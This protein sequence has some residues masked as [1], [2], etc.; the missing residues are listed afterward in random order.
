MTPNTRAG[1]AFGG[2]DMAIARTGRSEPVKMR[3]GAITVAPRPQ[4]SPFSRSPGVHP[5]IER[6]YDNPGVRFGDRVKGRARPLSAA[7]E[8]SCHFSQT[9]VS[10]TSPIREMIKAARGGRKLTGSRAAAQV[11]YMERDGA[12]EQIKLKEREKLQG[13][14]FVTEMERC[15]KERSPAAQ[16][17]YIDRQGAAE[18]IERVPGR[19]MTD[20]DLDGLEAA[21]FGTIGQ[22]V[23]E[24][25]N[26]WLSVEA[27]ERTPRGDI[28]RIEPDAHPEWWRKAQREISTAPAFAHSLLS[29]EADRSTPDC[30]EWK[31][32]TE[33]AFA[34]HEWAV[35]V[36]PDAPI[37]IEPGHGGRTQTRIIAELPY[38][39]DGR[40]RLQIVR[41]FTDMLAEKGFPFWA[42]IHAPDTNNDA[43]NYHV[44]IAYYDRPA[45]KMK[46]PGTDREVWDFEIQE[47]VT[48]KNR[49]KHLNRPYQQNR[50]RSTH[51]REWITELRK[52]WET[53]SNRVLEDAGISKRYNLGTYKSMGIDL[54]PLKHINSRTFNKERKGELT[55]DGPV[56]ARRQWD[57]IYDRLVRDHEQRTARRRSNIDAMGAIA[58]RGAGLQERPRIRCREVQR[59]TEIG[60]KA[61][62]Q[63]G[64]LE[65]HQ[66]LTR[67]VTDRV[68]SRPKLILTA[69]EKEDVKAQ[70][71]TA[72]TGGKIQDSPVAGAM[73][74]NMTHR[75]EVVAFLSTVYDGA[76]KIELDA[77]KRAG[78]ARNNVR[79]IVQELKAWIQAPGRL[80]SGP[81]RISEDAVQHLDHDSR[82][83]RRDERNEALA[84]GFREFADR[85]TAEIL[86]GIPATAPESSTKSQAGET[87]P[88][89]AP[90]NQAKPPIE[91][92]AEAGVVT[93]DSTASA[94]P[95]LDPNVLTS[96]PTLTRTETLV[97]P[98]AT[99]R[100]ER[101]VTMPVERPAPSELR[102]LRPKPPNPLEAD[103]WPTR[104]RSSGAPT[105]PVR[106][107]PGPSPKT[108]AATTAV[109]PEANKPLCE[110]AAST[111]KVGQTIPQA[112]LASQAKSWGTTRRQDGGA[113]AANPGV[114]ESGRDGSAMARVGDRSLFEGGAGVVGLREVALGVRRS[115]TAPLTPKRAL[116][117]PGADLV[118]S[119]G[120]SN[121]AP[122]P[123]PGLRP[124][125]TVPAPSSHCVPPSSSPGA[126][127][128]AV[129]GSATSQS[130]PEAPSKPAAPVEARA[131]MEVQLVR[132]PASP[133]AATFT[134]SASPAAPVSAEDRASIGRAAARAAVSPGVVT[135]SDAGSDPGAAQ[136]SPIQ[137]S[138]PEP[139]RD[140]GDRR[141]DEGGREPA[142][143]T[144]VLEFPDGQLL[145]SLP[146]MVL[147]FPDAA[148]PPDHAVPG[149]AV[150]KARLKPRSQGS[151]RPPPLPDPK[152]RRGGMGD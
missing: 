45:A 107:E 144:I 149:K 28:V 116:I 68:A 125:V 111:L 41:D 120:R 58:L 117:D 135:P 108:A 9:S 3:Y 57:N 150:D 29:R 76:L 142:R 124:P 30:V 52:H 70:K 64:L 73:T 81:T 109:K 77:A 119:S 143:P 90:I 54:V 16:Q 71:D 20:D 129:S 128:R 22:T 44:H 4:G 137:A 126:E 74:F 103:L 12:P 25:T 99:T 40:E 121:G 39:L 69:A 96:A 82:T 115:S 67:F 133:T 92:M 87:I 101:H 118:A 127:T 17:A 95:I 141:Y 62:Y 15:A 65:L 11:L 21:S 63:L 98:I 33:N 148:W 1:Q 35:G 123:G 8:S 49:T 75:S 34:L 43:R 31:V 59:L 104:N 51:A 14:A 50:D 5:A 138:L 2:V 38:E 32:S 7:G 6:A 27:S 24:R 131:A 60:R 152:N 147:E 134:P 78:T 26:F 61:S 10:K 97:K 110:T 53:V 56:L 23:E 106:A 18:G 79:I 100:V 140:A 145:D 86:K 102:G 89:A 132:E 136:T 42:V 130:P 114:R 84:Q 46:V 93:T 94:A 105:R 85:N 55:E 146:D 37:S 19:R 13:E 151:S 88:V 66:D 83:S 139:A 80:L 72:R 47:E 36:D 122:R 91:E 112:Q 113:Q 48:W